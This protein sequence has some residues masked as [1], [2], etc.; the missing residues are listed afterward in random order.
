MRTR[1]LSPDD[2]LYEEQVNFLQTEVAEFDYG[3]GDG[4]RDSTFASLE[5]GQ[6]RALSD[7]FFAEGSIDVDDIFEYRDKLLEDR[8]ELREEAMSA[9][10]DLLAYMKWP[11]EYSKQLLGSS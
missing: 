5:A 9:L 4:S 10:Q 7:Y 3:D 11:D 8:P 6:R 1:P 2:S